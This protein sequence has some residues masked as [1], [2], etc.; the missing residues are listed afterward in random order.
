MR[1]Q[2][3]SSRS[4]V[5]E[6]MHDRP[7][8]N[9]LGSCIVVAVAQDDKLL[10]FGSFA[11]GLLLSSFIDTDRTDNGKAAGATVTRNQGAVSEIN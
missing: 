3:E 4:F 11:C 10:F 8:T 9:F 1:C 2:A 7:T 5:S 6:T